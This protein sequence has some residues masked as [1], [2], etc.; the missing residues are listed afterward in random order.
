MWSG[1]I[2]F[3]LPLVL[4]CW[5]FTRER[6]VRPVWTEA[7]LDLTG[8]VYV[9]FGLPVLVWMMHRARLRNSAAYRLDNKAMQRQLDDEEDSE[10][11]S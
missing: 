7:L 10:L 5:I 2:V 11:E 9:V 3:L 6:G 4:P 8:L 1:C